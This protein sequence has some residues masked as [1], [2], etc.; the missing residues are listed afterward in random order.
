[1]GIA[2]PTPGLWRPAVVIDQR[3]MLRRAGE[4]LYGERWQSEL[5]RAVGVSDRTMRRWVSDPCEIPGG[6]WNDIQDLLLTRCVAIEKVRNEIIRVIPDAPTSMTENRQMMPTVNDR[7]IFS[8]LP[9]NNGR[10]YTSGNVDRRN[11][12]R[13]ADFGWLEGVSTNMSDVEYH[14]TL[15]GRLE[16]ELLKEA[17][18]ME[19]DFP[20][21]APAGFQTRVNAGPRRRAGIKLRVGGRVR[22]GHHAFTVD[23]IENEVVTV[24]TG[25]GNTYTLSL[26]TSLIGRS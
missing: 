23:A 21:P 9:F 15:A 19:G 20:D 3:E 12:D 24:R 1:M 11:Y 18:A 6:V 2:P 17:A 26:P 10:L 13:L 14:L 7:Q 8:E 22:L 25:D 5:S 16:L 4:A